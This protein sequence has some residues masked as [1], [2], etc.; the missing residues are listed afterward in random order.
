M[1]NSTST[2]SRLSAFAATTVIVSSDAAVPAI[3]CMAAAVPESSAK[4][5]FVLTGVALA[6]CLRRRTR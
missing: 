4:V 3:P 2:L 6:F 5:L 1:L